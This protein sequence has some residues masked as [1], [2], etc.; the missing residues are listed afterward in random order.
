MVCKRRWM[1]INNNKRHQQQQQQP[2]KWLNFFASCVRTEWGS[3][4]VCRQRQQ[5]AFSPKYKINVEG[6][7]RPSFRVNVKC[8]PRKLWQF[9]SL[10]A[11]ERAAALFVRVKRVEFNLFSD[12]WSRAHK[13]ETSSLFWYFRRVS[14]RILPIPFLCFAV[15]AFSISSSF[16]LSSHKELTRRI[17][18]GRKKTKRTFLLFSLAGMKKWN[19]RNLK[20]PAQKNQNYTRMRELV[21]CIIKLLRSTNFIS[22][23]GEVDFTSQET[24]NFNNP[25]SV[26]RVSRAG[27]EENSWKNSWNLILRDTVVDLTRESSR[28]FF[29]ILCK[30]FPHWKACQVPFSILKCAVWCFL[31]REVKRIWI[32][33]RH[34]HMTSSKEKK[35]NGP[36]H[37]WSDD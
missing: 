12:E 18:T 1:T 15:G 33:D 7:F 8:E 27:D 37:A 31:E 32:W 28:Y 14:L 17:S 9:I 6:E 5:Q 10:A 3:L 16:S 11:A 34:I 19:L 20:T 13:T 2:M 21:K 30:S 26:E 23:R 36:G 25:L 4:K 29:E 35:H 22:S 24:F